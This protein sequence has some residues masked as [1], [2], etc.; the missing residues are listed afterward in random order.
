[1]H[2]EILSAPDMHSLC[3]KGTISPWLQRLKME[4]YDAFFFFFTE[5]LSIWVLYVM[6]N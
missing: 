3:R 2:L 5:D 4:T 1:M 6:E